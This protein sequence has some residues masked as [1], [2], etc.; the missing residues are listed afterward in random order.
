MKV[1]LFLDDSDVQL[2]VEEAQTALFLLVYLLF[3]VAVML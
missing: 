1:F 3:F 2:V